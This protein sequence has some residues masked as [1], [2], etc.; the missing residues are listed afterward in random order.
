MQLQILVH[1][2]NFKSDG[3]KSF[4]RFLRKEKV[5]EEREYQDQRSFGKNIFI[6]VLC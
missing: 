5:K 4:T 1:G 6:L 2:H 3:E